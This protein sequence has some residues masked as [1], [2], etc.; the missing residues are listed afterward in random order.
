MIRV[1]Y[2]TENTANISKLNMAVNK[3]DESEVWSA[4]TVTQIK[5]SFRSHS[6]AL[7]TAC[8]QMYS[9]TSWEDDDG[10]G[11]EG[12]NR[13]Q[14]VESFLSVLILQVCLV[15]TLS[16]VFCLSVFDSL[17]SSFLSF[18]KKDKERNNILLI[19]CQVN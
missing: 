18:Q 8:M 15:F 7:L 10:A 11:D 3:F 1:I 19:Q 12:N 17:L 14:T 9:A 16:S 5:I 6:I 13:S 4:C 2:S